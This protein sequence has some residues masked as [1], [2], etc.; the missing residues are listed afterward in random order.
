MGP[1]GTRNRDEGYQ[2]GIQERMGTWDLRE[3]GEGGMGMENN[4]RQ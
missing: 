2:N 3:V 1:Q 4:G